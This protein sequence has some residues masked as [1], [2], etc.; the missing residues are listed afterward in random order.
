MGDY[1]YDVLMIGS[2]FGGSV[3]ALRLTEKGYRVGVFESG[4]RWDAE[5]LPKSNWNARKSIWAPKLGLTGTLRISI[6]GKCLVLSG[7]AVGGGSIIY[8][9]TLYQPLD[10][11]YRDKQWAHITDWKTELAPYYDQ[12][13]RMLGVDANPRV[14]P[15]DEVVKQIADDLGVGHTFHATDVGW[16]EPVPDDH[17]PGRAGNVILAEQ[18]RH[19]LAPGVGRAVPTPRTG[20]A[21]AAGRPGDSARCP[22]ADRGLTTARIACPYCERPSCPTPSTPSS[23]I[24]SN[25]SG[26]AHVPT[27]RCSTPGGRHVRACRFGRPLRSAVSSPASL[28]RKAVPALRFPPRGQSTC[29]SIAA[30]LPTATLSTL[31]RP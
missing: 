18:G 8:G 13:K 30:V 11:F 23:S 14:T 28:H 1:D 15:A 12:A 9:N 27:A 3:T 29:A 25:G 17:R 31:R 2:G 6:L 20:A 5:S 4:R 16:R 26:R 10:P 19:A 22:A 24:S 7:A 21:E